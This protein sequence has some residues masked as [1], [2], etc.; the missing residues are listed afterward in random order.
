MCIFACVRL[1]AIRSGCCGG[2]SEGSCE[3]TGA[4]LGTEPISSRKKAV[5]ALT[6]RHVSRPSRSVFEKGSHSV[7]QYDLELLFKL[8]LSLPSARITGV[9]HHA[10]QHILLLL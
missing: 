10:E 2:Q 5:K 6:T 3:L 4:V 1:S 7:N 9:S 8:L